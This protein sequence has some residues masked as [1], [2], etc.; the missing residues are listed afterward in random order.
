M[1]FFASLRMTT[2]RIF[3]K[4]SP[5]LKFQVQEDSMLPALKPGDVVLVNKLST[6]GVGDV[7]VLKNPEDQKMLLIK[8]IQKVDDRK[9]FV[10]GNDL[11]KSRDSRH[12]GLVEK[13]DIIGKVFY[14][15]HS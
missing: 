9:Y 8:K 15:V 5:I 2:S 13:K 10:M 7:I 6:P 1:R 12:F 11:K 3:F 14:V 4:I